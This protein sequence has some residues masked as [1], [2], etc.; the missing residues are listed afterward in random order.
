MQADRP[1]G[2]N[3]VKIEGGT[4]KMMGLDA[5]TQV[6]HAIQNGGSMPETVFKKTGQG[7]ISGGESAMM[8]FKTASNNPH[9]MPVPLGRSW[10]EFP[11]TRANDSNPRGAFQNKVDSRN[12][13]K[14]NE[15]TQTHT[16]K[17]HK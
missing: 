9:A 4:P 10:S 11:V 16:G 8:K 14:G 5:T 1:T 2:Y 12:I 13:M 15:T 7:A 6:R 17:S 3:T